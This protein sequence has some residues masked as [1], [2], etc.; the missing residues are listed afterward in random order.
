MVALVVV[1]GVLALFGLVV[2]TRHLYLRVDRPGGFDCSLRV[3]D[4]EVPGLGPTF[5]AGYAGPEPTRLRW[6]RVAW[7][8]PS[9]VLPLH[10]IALD[11]ARS[12]R[13]GERRSV[14]ARFMVVPFVA[15]DGTTLEL[16][17]P[18][19]R[20]RRLVDLLHQPPAGRQHR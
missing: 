19:R 7:P 1:L 10:G 12:P 4:G 16:A 20:L 2:G 15:D 13:S 6:R 11:Q 14:P 9:V 5:R 17:L 8:G 18:R 3:V